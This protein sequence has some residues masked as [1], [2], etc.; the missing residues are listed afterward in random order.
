M[1]SGFN[2]N[3]EIMA[4]N[5]NEQGT[6]RIRLHFNDFQTKNNNHVTGACAGYFKALSDAGRSRQVAQID[7]NSMGSP[8]SITFNSLQ[9]LVLSLNARTQSQDEK[10]SMDG[11]TPRP[12]AIG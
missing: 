10:I 8:T 11:V 4:Q 5:L 2:A 6:P 1:G 7:F 9:D 12:I 3:I